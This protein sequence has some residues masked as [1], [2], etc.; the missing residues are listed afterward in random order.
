VLRLE[1]DLAVSEQRIERAVAGAAI[2]SMPGASRPS[3]CVVA[4]RVSVRESPF[5]DRPRRTLAAAERLADQRTEQ[6]PS[7]STTASD[8]G[9]LDLHEVNIGVPP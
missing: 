2:R 5:D 7:A 3:M 1:L 6:R 8:C 9:S 4:A